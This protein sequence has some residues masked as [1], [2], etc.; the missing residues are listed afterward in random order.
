MAISCP[1][2]KTHNA[3]TTRLVATKIEGDL[4]CLSCANCQGILLSLLS[5]RNWLE[6]HLWFQLDEVDHQPIVEDGKNIKQCPKC[7]RLMIKYQYANEDKLKLDLCAHCDEIW[8]DDGEWDFLKFQ[9][10]YDKLPKILTEPWQVQL[11]KAAHEKLRVE[12]YKQLF[13]QDY[14]RVNEIKIF[15]QTNPQ[16]EQILDYLRFQD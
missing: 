12:K 15:I 6:S 13:Q 4:P 8:L 3:A 2:C 10:L 9:G 11:K 5:Y 1:S 16:R 14:T 7:E